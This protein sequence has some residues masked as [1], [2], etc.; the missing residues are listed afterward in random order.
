MLRAI[1]DQRLLAYGV[2]VCDFMSNSLMEKHRA[3]TSYVQVRMGAFPYFMSKML[4]R[5]LIARL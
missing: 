2:Q 3:L 5:G 1:K 4:T